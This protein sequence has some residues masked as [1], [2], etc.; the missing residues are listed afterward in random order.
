VPRT[1]VDR[2]DGLTTSIAVKAP[3][4]C[5]TTANITLSGLQTIDGVT[6]VGDDIYPPDRVLVKDQTDTTKNGIYNPSVN[7]WTRS[8]D[9]DGQRDITDGSLVWVR[10]GNTNSGLWKAIA[11]DRT[12][13][14]ETSEILFEQISFGAPT[15]SVVVREVFFNTLPTVGEIYPIANTAI[16]LELAADLVGC[17]FYVDPTGLPTSAATFTLYKRTPPAASVSIGT[18]EFATDGTVT[19]TFPS[20]VQFLTADGDKFIMTAPD[21]QDATLNFV[22]FAFLF[23]AI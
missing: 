17:Q 1:Q 18:I 19:V 5:A 15:T 21:P 9:F 8:L 13:I 3:C 7:A 10:G 6:V 22:A 16:D 12:V 4:T 2:I 23:T 14:I 11:T 20:A